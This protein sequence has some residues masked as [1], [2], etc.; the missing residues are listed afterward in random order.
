MTESTTRRTIEITRAFDAPRELVFEAFTEAE[1][2]ARWWGPD[3]F[4]VSLAESDPRV[5]GAL[6]LVMRGGD[7]ID[8]PLTGVYR[9]VDPPER[10]VVESSALA[11]DGRPLLSSRHMVTFAES[12]GRTEV[13]L[14]AEATALNPDAVAM[15]GGMYAGWNQS[16]QCLDDMLSGSVD[17]QLVISRLLVAQPE[18][19]FDL[20]TSPE[21]VSRWWGPLG[22]S[23]TTAEMD[24]RPGGTWRFTMHG[25]DGVDYPNTIVYD[26]VERPSRLVYTHQEP[27]FQ[28]IV[29][30]DE[31]MGMTALSM[32]QVFASTAERDLVT[33]KFHAQQG[34]E[35]TLDRLAE[36]V[37]ALS[38]TPA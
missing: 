1:H 18:R 34:A 5:G 22:F 25:P 28:G 33:E 32:R 15:L 30:F 17:R 27:R 16:L 23:I 12:K 7:G 14:V 2:L 38:P 3:G 19:V 13:T 35:Q 26:A 11:E 10:L 9:E 31:M 8:L 29:T 37:Q 36:M 24:V 21:H 20:W 6:K 4:S